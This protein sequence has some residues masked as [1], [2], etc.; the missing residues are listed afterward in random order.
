MKSFLFLFIFCFLSSPFSPPA[1]TWVAIGDSIT[2]LNDHQ[3][4]TGNRVTKGYLTRVTEELPDLTY[5]NQGHNGWTA[6]KMAQEIEKIGLVKADVYSVFLGTNDWWQGRPLGTLA[7]YQNNTGPATFYG[8]YRAII[9]KI[10]NLNTK[11][12]IVLIT[13]MP[14]VDFVSIANAKNNAYGSY[15]DKN[16]QSLAAFADAVKAIGKHEKL[17]VVDLYYKSGMTLENLVKFKRLKDPATGEYKNYPYPS[18]INVRFNPET[19]EYPYPPEAIDMT[20][21][22]LH[23]SDK[24]YAVISRMVT[25]VLKK[26]LKLKKAKVR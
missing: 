6:V 22:G 14:R 5:I 4:E 2:Y 21:D 20:Y 23:P 25:D 7:D 1:K 26:E 12:S 8:A 11:A 9:N 15:K 24:G 17:R 3:N 10:R 19:D 18:F 16:G 13:P